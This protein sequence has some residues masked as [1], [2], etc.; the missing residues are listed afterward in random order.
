[1]EKG[2]EG[3]EEGG[4]GRRGRVVFQVVTTFNQSYFTIWSYDISTCYTL[5]CADST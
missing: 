4:R 3:G 2:R 1:M 5:W